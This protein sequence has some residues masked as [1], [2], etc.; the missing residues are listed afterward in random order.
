MWRDVTF[1][2]DYQIAFQDFGVRNIADELLER[3][4][5]GYANGEHGSCSV[6][7][8]DKRFLNRSRPNR[9]KEQLPSMERMICG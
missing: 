7:P 2:G 8:R 5:G 9:G 1:C 3:V 4:R 6:A